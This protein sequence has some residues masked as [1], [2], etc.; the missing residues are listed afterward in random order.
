ME[1]HREMT[2]SHDLTWFKQELSTIKLECLQIMKVPETW[3]L[4]LQH[5]YTTVPVN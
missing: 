2:I 4:T 3:S 5:N 1:N